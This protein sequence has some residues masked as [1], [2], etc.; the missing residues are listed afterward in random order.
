M[1]SKALYKLFKAFFSLLLKSAMLFLCWVYKILPFS[2][3]VLGK[4][5]FARGGTTYVVDKD[6]V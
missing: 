3:F 1:T 4:H 6:P 5:S 2:V